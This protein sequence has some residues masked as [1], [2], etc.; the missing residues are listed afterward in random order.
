MYNRVYSQANRSL[1]PTLC[2]VRTFS[3]RG[4]APASLNKRSP[5]AAAPAAR[6]ALSQP[7]ALAVPPIG[8]A[9]QGFSSYTAA[10]S[11]RDGAAVQV[12]EEILGEVPLVDVKKVLV[13]GSGG[14]S[15]GQAGEFDYSGKRNIVSL[16]SLI[17]DTSL[18]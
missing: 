11:A 1:K 10:S 15:I 9:T 14:L 6:R 13:V 16:L 3:T 7:K 18:L 2:S 4:M 5:Y 8:A 17:I 12:S